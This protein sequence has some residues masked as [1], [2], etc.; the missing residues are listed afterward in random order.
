[1]L[2]TH[3]LRGEYHGIV[4]QK[5]ILFLCL[6]ALQRNHH[7][8]KRSVKSK[9]RQKDSFKCSSFCFFAFF[10]IFCVN[11]YLDLSNLNEDKF[12]FLIFKLKV[13]R[14]WLRV[15]RQENSNKNVQSKKYWKFKWKFTQYMSSCNNSIFL[16]DADVH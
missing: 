5:M 2:R 10:Y 12:Q 11:F 14:F 3:L 7:L 16:L 9:R 4:T 6:L 8:L 13:K 15:L 1:M